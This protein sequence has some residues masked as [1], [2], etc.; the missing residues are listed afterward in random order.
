M[1]RLTDA[2]IRVDI[3]ERGAVTEAHKCL[4]TVNGQ[5]CVQHKSQMIPVQLYRGR[6]VAT[7]KEQIGEGK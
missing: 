1:S 7:V 3:Y 5:L 2:R 4:H 6:W